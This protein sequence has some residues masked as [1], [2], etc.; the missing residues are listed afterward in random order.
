[1]EDFLKNLKEQVDAFS[2]VN[3]EWSTKF[4]TL[5][6]WDS[7]ALLTVMAFVASEYKAPLKGFEI[8][9]CD[10]IA[11]IWQRVEEKRKK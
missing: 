8:L 11:D 10:T 1:M 5:P 6:D 9:E 2:N 3:L 7:L 4:Q